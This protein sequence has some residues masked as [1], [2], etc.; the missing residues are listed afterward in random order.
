MDDAD[1]KIYPFKYKASDYPL[2]TNSNMLIHLDTSVF[3]KAAN[4]DEAAI[5]VLENMVNK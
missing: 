3:F 1:S 4:A 5:A 2:N